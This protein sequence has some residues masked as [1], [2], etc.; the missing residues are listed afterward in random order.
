VVPEHISRTQLAVAASVAAVIVGLAGWAWQ[1]DRD[2]DRPADAAVVGAREAGDPGCGHVLRELAGDAGNHIDDEPITY[3]AAPPSFGDHRSR[4]EVRA[5]TFYEVGNRPEVPVLVHNLEHGYN[6]L[7]YDQTVVEDSAALAQVREIAE[8]YATLGRERDPETAFIAAPWTAAD[9]PG[10]PDGMHYALTHWYA[11]PTDRTRSRND[12]LG[13]T[14]YCSGI[15]AGVVKEWMADY[16][17]QDA[18]EGYPELM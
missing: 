13:L 16:P 8:G 14:R 18:P 17:L 6:I 5:L 4:W 12:E 10:F 1:Q 15:S 2:G 3:G 11:D 7:W 9:G